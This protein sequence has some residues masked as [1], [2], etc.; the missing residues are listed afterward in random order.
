MAVNV[1]VLV[2]G[3]AEDQWW[4]QG[5]LLKSNEAYWEELRRYM[6]SRLLDDMRDG[7]YQAELEAWPTKRTYGEVSHRVKENRIIEV[8]NDLFRLGSG[9]GRYIESINGLPTIV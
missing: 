2:D 6:H 9:Q 4:S 1:T 7:K 8:I 3:L 5:G